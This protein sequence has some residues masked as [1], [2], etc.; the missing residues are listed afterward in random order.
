VTVF[1]ASIQLPYADQ[2]HAGEP[3]AVRVVQSE[4]GP[5]WLVVASPHSGRHYPK[6][7]LNAARLDLRCLRQAE[8]AWMDLLLVGAADLGAT[9]IT[10]DFARSWVDLNRAADELD[11]L[12]IKG[13]VASQINNS[14]RVQ[15]GLGVIPRSVGEAGN[16]YRGRLTREEAS[17]RLASVH[18]PYHEALEAALNAAHARH[19]RVML[20][21]CHS[22][23]AGACDGVGVDMVLGDR[24]GTSCGRALVSQVSETLASLGFS[25][26]RNAPFAGGY[27]T[28]R[29][30]QPQLGRHALQIEISRALYMN[31][32]TLKPHDGFERVRSALNMVVAGLLV[33]GS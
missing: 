14:L 21:D 20:L 13:V 10:T 17:E 7:M 23:P 1:P 4:A 25:V 12:L 5:S 3:T 16:I 33:Q 29:H 2:L 19:G 27:V 18:Q 32:T 8:D 6:S 22:M 24:F 31:E 30:G 26:A 11:P 28:T 9:F 15:A